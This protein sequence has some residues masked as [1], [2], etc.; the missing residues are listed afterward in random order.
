MVFRNTIG[1]AH[2]FAKEAGDTTNLIWSKHLR[3]KINLHL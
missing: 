3:G 2:R 1:G